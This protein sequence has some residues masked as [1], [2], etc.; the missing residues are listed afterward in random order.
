MTIRKADQS[1]S[2][3]SSSYSQSKGM[4]RLSFQSL[5]IATSIQD[6]INLGVVT[7]EKRPNLKTRMKINKKK[8]LM[9]S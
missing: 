9:N 7:A 3:S 6:L 2:S 8:R 1:S 5:K 4:K